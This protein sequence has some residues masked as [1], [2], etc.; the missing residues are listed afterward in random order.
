MS[1]KPIGDY[2]VL[3][4]RHSAAL[5]SRDGSVDWLC[6]PHFDS[7]SVFARLL[8]E[9]AGSWSL[10]AVDATSITRRYVERTMVLETT[11]TTPAGTAVVLDALAVGKGN[12][13]HDLG[14]DSPHLLLRHATC[15]RGEVELE[16]EYAPRPGY[17]LVVPLL[18]AVDG[19]VV[20]ASGD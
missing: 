16:M 1:T 5:A 13:G 11:Y 2:A 3:S 8:G 18:T 6:F 7:P 15:S 19:G 14:R 4:D 12:R 17:G 10:R 9:Q 20:A